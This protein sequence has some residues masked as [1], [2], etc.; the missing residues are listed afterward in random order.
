M[1]E[2]TLTPR[3]PYLLR[4][5]YDWLLDNELT[6][7][8]VVDAEQPG[9]Q[10]PWE[11]V[12]DGQIVL[13]ISPSAVG[14][15]SISNEWVQFNARFSGKPQHVVVPM[16]AAIALYARENGSGSFFEPE[17]AYIQSG[18]AETELT[19]VP[20]P[21]TQAEEPKKKPG[22]SHLRVVK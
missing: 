1:S 18:D 6:P 15:L 3:R 20:E 10:L 19:P 12:Q 22:S 9:C 7:H 11:F 2:V 21:T 13:N 16:A 5:I 8:L 4:A 17:E 14:Q